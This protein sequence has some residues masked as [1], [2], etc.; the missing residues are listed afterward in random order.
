MIETVWWELRGPPH[1]TP[2]DD[3]AIIV[4]PNYPPRGITPPLA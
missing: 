3:G 1:H 4:R 2:Q